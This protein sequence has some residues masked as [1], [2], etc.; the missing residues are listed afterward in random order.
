[1]ANDTTSKVRDDDVPTEKK[2]DE[3]YDLIDG[4]EVAMMTTRAA[5]GALVSRAMQTQA[6]R[7]GTDLW[8]MAN[9]ESGKIAELR[10]DPHVNLSYYRDRT[11]E[12]VSVSGTAVVT[13]DRA[14]VHELYKPSWRAW[15][16]DEG[17]ERD[18]GPD[19][20]RIA[21]IEVEA[22]SVTYLKVNQPRPVRLFQIAKAMVTGDPPKL[23]S[24]RE[25]DAGQL[26]TGAG[27]TK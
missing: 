11:R 21:L 18:G 15:L 22:H 27:R 1:M 20:P 19:D 13:Q 4:I 7:P 12:W 9:A 24:L 8:F 6:R 16:G 2:L 17:G 14:R 10:A 5:D 25:L 3:L 26:A 23:G